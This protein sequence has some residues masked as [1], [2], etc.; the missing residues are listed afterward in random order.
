[1]CPPN[2]YGCTNENT[3]DIHKKLVVRTS[4]IK[5]TYFAFLVHCGVVENAKAKARAG[6]ADRHCGHPQKNRAQNNQYGCAQLAFFSCEIRVVG[7]RKFFV[8]EEDI[9]ADMR[10]RFSRT[11]LATSSFNMQRLA[12][13]ANDDT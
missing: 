11:G 12:K 5:Y 10:Y 7:V 8:R 13:E 6:E 3:A 2:S 1:M 4:V 9:S